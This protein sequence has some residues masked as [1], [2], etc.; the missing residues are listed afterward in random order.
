MLAIVMALVGFIAFSIPATAASDPGGCLSVPPYGGQGYLGTAQ[1]GAEFLAQAEAGL[2]LDSGLVAF[3]YSYLVTSPDFDKN[4][5]GLVCVWHYE[6][7]G[8]EVA[9]ESRGFDTG[10]FFLDNNFPS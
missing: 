2:P 10:F 1:E 9:D 8:P 5:D 7:G 3:Y 4:G 6:F